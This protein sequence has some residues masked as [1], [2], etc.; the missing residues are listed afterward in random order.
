[1]SLHALCERS[2]RT[3]VLSCNTGNEPAVPGRSSSLRMR[4]GWSAGCP[5]R[6][7][8]WFPRTERTLRLPP[9][10]MHPGWKH[11]QFKASDKG[12]RWSPGADV[13]IFIAEE[14]SNVYLP[15]T[16]SSP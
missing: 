2:M 14:V 9:G 7:I 3:G 1:M 5:I 8:H 12:G 16:I 13:Y 10:N 6:N 4:R 11:F 15:L